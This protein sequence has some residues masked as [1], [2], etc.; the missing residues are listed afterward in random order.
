MPQVP[1]EAGKSSFGLIDEERF[2]AALPLPSVRRALDLGCGAGRYTLA[3]AER[4][5]AGA[6]VH[7]VD[8]WAEGVEK[9]RRGARERGLE[10]VTADTGDLADL[11]AVPDARIDLVLLATVLHDLAERGEAAAALAEASR[12]LRPRG[13]LAVVEFKKIPTEH[14]PPVA[15]RLSPGDLAALVTPFGFAE[16]R[17]VD[18]GPNAYLALFVRG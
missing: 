1:A 8:L 5:P 11:G 10:H 4:L 6:S 14:G 12:I 16:P 18:L 17:V 7:G 13:W 2:F 9:L 3:L 15:I